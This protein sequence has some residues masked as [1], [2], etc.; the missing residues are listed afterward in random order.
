MEKMSLSPVCI[1]L[2]ASLKFEGLLLL[3][4]VGR[5][6]KNYKV[7]FLLIFQNKFFPACLQDM[8]SVTKIVLLQANCASYFL[9]TPKK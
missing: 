5:V 8:K 4:N 9:K 6:F 1:S 3:G 7:C 2:F